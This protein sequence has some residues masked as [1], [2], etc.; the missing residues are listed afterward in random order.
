MY[1]FICKTPTLIVRKYHLKGRALMGI[2]IRGMSIEDTEETGKVIVSSF[3]DVFIKHGFPAPFPAWQI[4]QGIASS[5]A[6]HDPEGCIIALEGGKIVGSGFIHLRGET[7]T[8][9][10]VSVSPDCQNKG[11]GRALMEE[12]LHIGTNSSSI[13]LIQDSFNLVSFSLYARLSFE[14]KDTVL[15]MIMEGPEDYQK[16]GTHFACQSERSEFRIVEKKDLPMVV[17]LDKK[18]LGLDRAKDFQ[19]LINEGAGF[20]HKSR[21]SQEVTGFMLF[22]S[23]RNKTIFIGPGAALTFEALADLLLEVVRLNR[24]FSLR[25]KILASQI[26]L[27]QFLLKVGF[28]VTGIGTFMVRGNYQ[29]PSGQQLLAQFPEVL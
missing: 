2:V 9:G 16:T 22:Y 3:N 18:M 20:M 8:I 29:K 6:R 13:R 23:Y 5:Y 24:G 19:L 21:Q 26:Q 25:L 27:L 15:N 14:A 4:G 12:L 17:S 11:I 1:V 7:A 28:K 10:P